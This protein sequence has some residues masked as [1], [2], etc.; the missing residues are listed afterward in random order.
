[1]RDCRL[2]GEPTVTTTR[3]LATCQTCI[4]AKARQAKLRYHASEKG[5]QTTHRYEQ[6]PQVKE[7]RRLASRAPQ[8]R[9]N[10]AK[11]EQTA[12]G[13]ATRKKAR[14]K[15]WTSPHGK[16]RQRLNDRKRK[17]TPLSRQTLN[18]TNK[19]YRSTEKGKAMKARSR[20]KRLALKGLTPEQAT[21]TAAQWLETLKRAHYRC[22]Y[23]KKK[24]PL[25]MDHVIPLSKGGLHTQENV[26]PA[27]RECNSSKRDQILTLL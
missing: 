17:L 27:C 7:R 10:K 9:L 6:L 22:Y 8:G 11:Y 5:Q 1:M 4:K 16:A 26:V 3:G 15:Y 2:C 24:R 14:I 21:L 25:T 23:C 19:R 18:A 12:K 13:Q 20:A